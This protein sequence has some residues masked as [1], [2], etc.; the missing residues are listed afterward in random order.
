MRRATRHEQMGPV[1]VNGGVHTARKQHQRKNV[2]IC[3]R[4]LRPVWIGPEE[5][6]D[7]SCDP[8]TGQ[9]CFVHAK[10]STNSCV[11]LLTRVIFSSAGTG[12]MS[13]ICPSQAPV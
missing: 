3:A 1:D 6:T 9:L 13:Q 12:Y 10:K 11:T 8:P 2:P 7:C 5:N 4:V